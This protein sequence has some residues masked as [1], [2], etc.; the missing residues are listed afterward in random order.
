MGEKSIQ[1]PRPDQNLKA[2]NEGVRQMICKD[3][4]TRS[5]FL[6]ILLNFVEAFNPMGPDPRAI[7]L[8]DLRHIS[9]VDLSH[10]LRT[11]ADKP[12]LFDLR[13]RHELDCFPFTICDSLQVAELGWEDLLYFVPSQNVVILYGANDESVEHMTIPS[14]PGDFEVWMLRGGLQEWCETGLPVNGLHDQQACSEEEA[15]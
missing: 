13:N 3:E 7:F 5:F 4:Q 2:C 15:R 1:N 11:R 6:R 9:P 12:I 8:R 14:L 10:L